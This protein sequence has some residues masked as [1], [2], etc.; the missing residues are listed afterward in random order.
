MGPRGSTARFLAL[1]CTGLFP[2]QPTEMSL[3]VEAKLLSTVVPSSLTS[4]VEFRESF[5]LC[6]P[7]RIGC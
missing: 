6:P 5:V 3:M 7:I 1:F 2:V 4:Q